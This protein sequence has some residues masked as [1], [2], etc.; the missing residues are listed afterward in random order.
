MWNSDPRAGV[1]HVKQR[2]QRGDGRTVSSSAQFS[3]SFCR[4][5]EGTTRQSDRSLTE[6]LSRHGPSLSGSSPG[7]ACSWYNGAL[8]L[9]GQQQEPLILLVARPETWALSR[10]PLQLQLRQKNSFIILS[11]CLLINTLQKSCPS[12]ESLITVLL[13]VLEPPTEDAYSFHSTALPQGHKWPSQG[14]SDGQ[15]TVLKQVHPS[16]P[17]GGPATPAGLRPSL[18]WPLVLLVFGPQGPLPLDPLDISEMLAWH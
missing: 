1:T 2:K 6:V 13:L 4:A 15:V 3:D 11:N 8:D 18:L 17:L 9:E 14:H 16:E 5:A 7:E 12:S 10:Q